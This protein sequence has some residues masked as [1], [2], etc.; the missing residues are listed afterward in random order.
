MAV[1]GWA[2]QCES[3]LQVARGSKVVDGMTYISNGKM[4]ISCSWFTWNMVYNHRILIF[5][6]LSLKKSRNIFTKMISEQRKKPPDW[7]LDGCFR[8][9]FGWEAPN[10][11]HPNS[12]WMGFRR[13][14]LAFFWASGAKLPEPPQL[15]FFSEASLGRYIFFRMLDAKD[16]V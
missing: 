9:V 5:I 15:G 7:I 4:M 10:K 12:N 11:T 13:R 3:R 6:P 14:N 16:E 8:W 2:W 1:S